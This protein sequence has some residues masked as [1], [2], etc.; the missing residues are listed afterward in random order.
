MPLWKSLLLCACLATV[1]ASPASAQL[2]PEEAR[3]V[4]ITWDIL[5]LRP[6]GF[7][8]TVVGAALFVPVWILSSPAGTSGEI[9]DILIWEPYRLTFERELGRY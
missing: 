6:I 7:V 2:T 4:N 1:A 5:V 3:W 8:Q 9:A